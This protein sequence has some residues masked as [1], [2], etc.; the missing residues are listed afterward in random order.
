MKNNSQG[1]W[2]FAR[3]LLLQATVVLPSNKPFQT[4]EN[5]FRVFPSTV[6]DIVQ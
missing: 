1:T 6:Y 5:N 3:T 4:K 2:F